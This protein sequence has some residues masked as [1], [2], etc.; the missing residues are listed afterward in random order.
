[1]S[2]FLPKNWRGPCR[3]LLEAITPSF[4][5]R[6]LLRFQACEQ[7]VTVCLRPCY[8][9]GTDW[10]IRPFVT[11]SALDDQTTL[12]LD[13]VKEASG[14]PAQKKTLVPGIAQA[15]A[16]LEAAARLISALAPQPVLQPIPVRVKS[17]HRR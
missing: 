16:V 14:V 6:F 13:D 12:R 10:Q 5:R 3:G 2:N 8:A 7:F 15:K 9:P 4:R 1:M 17:N 11:I